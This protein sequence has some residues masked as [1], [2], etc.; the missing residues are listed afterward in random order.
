MPNW[1]VA[2]SRS[3]SL[4]EMAVNATIIHDTL[5]PEGWTLNA[6]CAMLGNM[7]L[8]S[9]INPGR[10]EG[11]RVGVGPG[12]G[13][14]QWTPYTKVTN[15]IRSTFQSEDFTSGDYQLARIVYEWQNEIQWGQTS[16]YPISFHEFAQSTAPLEY[17]VAA[18]EYNYE[19]GTPLLDI[20]TR[21]A[22]YWWDYFGGGAVRTLPIW[23]LAQFN[24]RG[25]TTRV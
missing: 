13:L 6:V 11:D 20:R 7:Q 25:V 14:T 24:K 21:Y 19:V 2:E 15:W 5:I 22:K 10:W 16:Q 17:L 4:E 23:L 9:T 1:V 3:L 12:F 18:F 8:E